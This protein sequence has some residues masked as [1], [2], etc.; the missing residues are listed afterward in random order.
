MHTISLGMVP[1]CL[2][3]RPAVLDLGGRPLLT[4]R[5]GEG[6]SEQALLFS[7]LCR[8]VLF[9]IIIRQFE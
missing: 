9:T 1:V 4:A 3:G 8:S 2:C 7:A 6:D 5:D